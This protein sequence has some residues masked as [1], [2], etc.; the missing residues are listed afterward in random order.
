[1]PDFDMAA[2]LAAKTPQQQF[3]HE[4]EHG[5]RYPP[6]IA[7]ALLETARNYLE[8]PLVHPDQRLAPGQV[9]VILA[10]RDAPAGRSLRDT[11]T[12]EVVWT[13]DNGADDAAIWARHGRQALRRVR[14]LRLLDEAVHQGAAATLEDLARRLHVSLRTIKRDV[15]CLRADGYALPS[16]G[17]LSGVGRG[18]SHK[19]IIVRLALEGKTYTEIEQRTHH[20]PAAIQRYVSDFCRVVWLHRRE[21]A[22]HQVGRIL[23]IGDG[24]VQ[25]YLELYRQYNVPSYQRQLDEMIARASGQYQ[26]PATE[27]EKGGAR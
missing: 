4:L 5:F 21:L 10:K 19:A 24:L 7:Q 15:A 8:R 2:R 27:R 26:A 12:T 17:K 25:E 14:I 16:R 18:Q 20:S 11:E 22:S 1:M 9:R 13:V 3:L 6:R 23:Q